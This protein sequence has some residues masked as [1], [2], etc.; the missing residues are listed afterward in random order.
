MKEL[1]KL[2][3]AQQALAEAKSLDEIVPLVSIGAG[4]LAYAKAAK[5]GLEMQ[6][7]CAEFKLRAERKAGEFLKGNLKHGGDRKSESRLHDATLKEYDIEKTQS[8]RWQKIA[9]V[10][11][12]DFENHIRETKK[13]KRE[14]TSSS[15][16]RLSDK[17]PS[18][19]PPLPADVFN[20]IYADPPWKYSNTGMVGMIEKQ[21]HYKQ[22]STQ[23]LCD[24]SIPAAENSVLFL[25]VTNPFLR[26]GLWVCGAW[27]FD[28]KSNIV[29]VKRSLKKPGIGFYVRGQ[30]ELLF[31]CIKGSFLPKSKAVVSSILEADIGK[32]SEKPK[33]VY[34]VIEKLYP[35]CKYLELFAREKR[36]NWTS[37]GD[38]L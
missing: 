2:N 20:V 36:E 38:E 15:V 32:H 37:W 28:Y 1:V 24:L 26:E 18:Q 17:Q 31:I 13:N 23:D 3:K 27:G 16:I 29:W 5:M 19:T 30:H 35:D 25:W 7:D 6:N 12:E 34:G 10:P 8:Y 33:I 14:L 11:D 4:G 22:M 21:G 9:C